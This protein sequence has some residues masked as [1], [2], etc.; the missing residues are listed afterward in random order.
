MNF[1]QER[2][3]SWSVS[4]KG[5]S[6]IV[7]RFNQQTDISFLTMVPALKSS[8]EFTKRGF[9]NGTIGAVLVHFMSLLLLMT[10]ILT[11]ITLV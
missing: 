10:I 9:Q 11:S 3:L 1:T 5:S 8:W 7:K 6:F 2:G 4:F